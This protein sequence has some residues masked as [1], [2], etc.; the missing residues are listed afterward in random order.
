M[1]WDF[2]LAMFKSGLPGIDIP[3][4]MAFIGILYKF[5][6]KYNIKTILNGGIFLLKVLIHLSTLCIGVRMRL[7]RDILKRFGTQKMKTY[8]FSSVFTID[9]I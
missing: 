3:Q 4:D 6:V 8:P 9:Y 7:I 1:K 5:A 2:Q